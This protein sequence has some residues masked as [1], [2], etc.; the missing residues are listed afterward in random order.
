MAW[1]NSAAAFTMNWLRR[2][3]DPWRR[4]FKLPTSESTKGQLELELRRRRVERNRTDTLAQMIE[5]YRAQD[6]ALRR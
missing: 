4:H 5:D 6:G 1:H 2:V 3:L